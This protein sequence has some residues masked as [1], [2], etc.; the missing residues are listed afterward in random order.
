MEFHFIP[1]KLLEAKEEIIKVH[2]KVSE[3]R[4]IKPGKELKELIEFLTGLRQEKVKLE[5]VVLGRKEIELVTRYLPYN[6]YHVNMTNLFQV[7]LY[8]INS[9]LC[10]ILFFEWQNSYEN[11]ECNAFLKM[12]LDT[13]EDFRNH[14]VTCGLNES[15][16]RSFLDAKSI[17][18]AY[19]KEIISKKNIRSGEVERELLRYGIRGN[20]KLAKQCRYL[21]WTFCHKRAY[22]ALEER[23]L[24][25]EIKKYSDAEKRE[26]LLNFLSELELIHLKQYNLIAA[27]FLT[28]TGENQSKRFYQ[29]FEQVPDT[30]IK[31]YVDWTNTYKIQEYFGD[32]E[33]SVFWQRYHHEVVTRYGYSN[34]VVMDFGDFVA[35]EF[36]GRSMGPCYIYKRAYF[37]QTFRQT[38]VFGKYKNNE[39]RQFLFKKTEF[40]NGATALMYHNGTRL[41]HNPN[42]GWEYNFE[43]VL[44]NNNITERL[45]R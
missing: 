6:F 18:I 39:L 1:H 37:D 20:S 38:N 4:E 8:R 21:Y 33:R 34:S 41:V 26:F 3:T 11:Q 10:E 24:L 32:D 45:F 2:T 17:P 35:I 29:Y 16:F 23:V 9:K 5:A 12:L 44:L 22:L 7:F 28:I 42:P 13:Q 30:I 31:K 27:H 43:Q 19:G 25:R 36:L 14:I 15:K 40:K